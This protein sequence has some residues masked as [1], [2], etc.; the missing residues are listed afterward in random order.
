MKIKNEDRK[1]TEDRR[2]Q[3]EGRRKKKREKTENKRKKIRQRG[4]LRTIP[5]N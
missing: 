5:E 4:R 3:T 2:W 1:K